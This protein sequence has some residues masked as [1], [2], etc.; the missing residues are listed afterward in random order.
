MSA[1][2]A[3]P[4]RYANAARYRARAGGIADSCRAISLTLAVSASLAEGNGAWGS[5][6]SS[7]EAGASRPSVRVRK[8][9]GTPRRGVAWQCAGV[10]P[11]VA[12]RGTTRPYARATGECQTPP[13][14]YTSSSIS[15]RTS[16]S[17]L[18]PDQEDRL[19]EVGRATGLDHP[20]LP[21]QPRDPR[22]VGT[23]KLRST[24]LRLRRVGD[25]DHPDRLDLDV[26]GDFGH[27]VSVGRSSTGRPRC[28]DTPRQ[29]RARPGWR[30]L[31]ARGGPGRIACRSLRRRRRT[32]SRPR[33]VSTRGHGRAASL[34]VPIRYLSTTDPCAHSTARTR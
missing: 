24:L 21:D 25:L 4:R 14:V 1:S 32:L 17:R 30:G 10:Y 19:V 7:G 20:S 12:S 23:A 3:R 15:A 6:G 11:E 9:I 16:A 27:G 8:L 22:Q 34:S 5:T 26:V 18:G 31:P 2:A 29:D 33:A 13:E 28:P